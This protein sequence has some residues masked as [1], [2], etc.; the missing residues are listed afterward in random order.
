MTQEQYEFRII[1]G[2]YER[3]LYGLDVRPAAASADAQSS[4]TVTTVFIYPAHISCI[5]AVAT[6]PRFLATGST[7]EHV[8]LYDLRL[9]KEVGTLM[10]HS[11]SITCLRFFKKS[12]LITASED[13]TIAIVRTQDWEVLKTLPGHK[14]A[15]NW[16][17]VHPSG[18]VLLSVGGDGTLKCWDLARGTCTYS[19]RLPRVAERVCW[20]PSGQRYAV[21]MNNLVQIHAVADGDVVGKVEGIGR[22]NAIAFCNMEGVDGEHQSREV[23]VT[24]GEDRSIGVWAQDGECILRW[25]TQHENRVKDLDVC[26]KEGKPT[27]VVS[28]S[29]DGGIKVWDLTDV[30]QQLKTNKPTENAVPAEG[31]PVK[32]VLPPATPQADYNAKCR[33]TCIAV[34][35]PFDSSSKGKR[36]DVAH[37]TDEA[38]EDEV[39]ADRSEFESD[40]E[41]PAGK[42]TISVSFEEEGE[43]TVEEKASVP[44]PTV[45]KKKRKAT[46]DGNKTAGKRQAG[47]GPIIKKGKGK[48]AAL[49]KF[50]KRSVNNSSK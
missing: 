24:G 50:R 1:V 43:T 13:G 40:Y 44:A 23:L 45:S 35:G 19:M 7:D 41:D 39:V 8:K 10:H 49:N 31:R 25:N 30:E 22:I 28:C 15:I 20:S 9:R 14:R 38:N 36:A 18:K 42:A 27:M 4:F 46:A 16:V 21:L 33:L 26:V 47:S 48:Q 5:K 3:L 11:G 29:S 12:H 6:S 2:T 17:D 37:V 32:V 34:T